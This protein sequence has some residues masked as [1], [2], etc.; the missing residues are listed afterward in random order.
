MQVCYTSL[1]PLSLRKVIFSSLN[2]KFS[3]TKLIFDLLILIKNSLRKL[4]FKR[5]T[6]TTNDLKSN[7]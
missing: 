3:T 6:R 7:Y 1:T 2:L 5:P 4:Y